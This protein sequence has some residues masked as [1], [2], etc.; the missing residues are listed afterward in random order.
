MSLVK[1]PE[2]GKEISDKSNTCIH[3]GYP[4]EQDIIQ[5]KYDEAK[6]IPCENCG[7]ISWYQFENSGELFCTKCKTFYIV[8][9]KQH[10]EYIHKKQQQAAQ[11]TNKPRC[12]RC[13][14]TEIQIVPKKW[15]IWSG[16]RTNEVERVCVKCKRKW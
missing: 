9:Q 14:C 1:C 11:D 3:C 13:G 4:I 8:D 12:P 15:S 10:N 6:K 7:N 5:N 16:F 2:C